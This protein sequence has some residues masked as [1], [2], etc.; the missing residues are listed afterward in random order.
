[1]IDIDAIKRKISVSEDFS[2]MQ[3]Q[4]EAEVSEFY[5]TFNDSPEKLSAWGHHYFCRDDGNVLRYDPEAPQSHQCPLCGKTYS[6]RL[7]DGVW[8]AIYRNEAALTVL[9]AAVLYKLTQERKYLDAVIELTGFYVLNFEKFPLHNKEGNIYE[10]LDSMKW[11]CGRIMPQNLNE[12]IFFTRIFTGLELVREELP[13]SLT[14]RI[15]REFSKQ[16]LALL[17][18][19]TDKIHNISCW[20]DCA[21]GIIG[22][23]CGDEEMVDFA[24]RGEYN[25]NRQ[26]EE[27]VTEDGFWY[28]GSIHY[29]CFIM[30]G[31]AYL[32]LFAKVR[33][34]EFRALPLFEKMLLSVYNYAFSNQGLPNPNDGWPH[35]NLKTYSYIYSIGAGIFGYE[36]R[37]GQ[38]LAQI[39]AGDYER[40]EIPLSKP[41]YYKNKLSLE[42]FLFI[43]DFSFD[44]AIKPNLLSMDFEKS[45]YALLK[46][47]KLNVFY[48][49]GH[50]GPS[51]AHPDKMTVE[52]LFGRELLTGDLSNSGYG[53]VICNE[54]HRVTASHNTVVTD[55][56]NH[57]S[58][59]PGMKLSFTKDSCEAKAEG[60]YED[61][62]FKRK[63][64]ITE[65]SFIDE[66]RVE[67]ERERIYDFIFHVEAQ[68]LGSGGG[69]PVEEADADLGFKDNGYAYFDRVK[70]LSPPDG[71]ETLT[72][73]WKLGNLKLES[74][75]DI[76][77]TRLYLARSPANPVTRYRTSIIL[78]RTARCS[79]FHMIWKLKRALPAT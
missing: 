70:S 62:S 22:L 27:G 31:L 57:A 7:L 13:P 5:K 56:M 29:N 2:G 50:H 16:I 41:Y 49:Y 52:V 42:Q 47:E 38:I 39:L 67:S 77:D 28:E 9:K 79:T 6:S 59:K 15:E 48:K 73:F 46:N 66:F 12:A 4:M 63:I 33:G 72:L 64:R 11:G 20:M 18:P 51:H 24:F 65:D 55:G 36:S 26:L 76:K 17:K 3:R 53:S 40:G 78:R 25:I 21:V 8:L 60:V 54:W 45:N 69:A 43:P 37:V 19:Q 10:S 23:Y 74:T 32:A 61:V 68:W 44:T 58:V 30:E 14:E 1:M 75:F 35:V 71:S 34:Q